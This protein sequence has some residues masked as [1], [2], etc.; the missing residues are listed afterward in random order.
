[1]EHQELAHSPACERNTPP[2]INFLQS[3]LKYP[4]SD[5]L[6]VGFGTGQHAFA[7]A[8]AFPELNYIAADQI[9]YHPHLLNRIKVLGR[10]KNLMGPYNLMSTGE[11]VKH[12][13]PQ[14]KFTT[15]FSANTLHIM[16]WPQAQALL[17]FLGHS[18]KKDGSIFLYGPFKFA[19]KF[20]SP[21]NENFHYSLQAQSPDMGIRNHEEICTILEAQD[22]KLRDVVEMP[23]NN[24]IL[25]FS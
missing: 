9:Q 3:Q 21:S 7:F 25:I 17:Q 15:I 23:A 20:T 19:G 12:N 6:E 11:T 1:M 8:H 22:L 18:L 4:N 13:L 2:L 10:P 16:S 24:N 14:E 5:F